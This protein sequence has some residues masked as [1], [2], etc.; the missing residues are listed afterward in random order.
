MTVEDW[1]RLASICMDMGGRYA[2]PDHALANEYYALAKGTSEHEAALAAGKASQLIEQFQLSEAMI[3]LDEPEAE[4]EPIAKDARLEPELQEFGGRGS[5]RK[6]VAWRETIARA[7]ASDLGIH[8]YWGNHIDM[9]GFGRESAIQTWRY[10]FQYLVRAV[11][12]LTDE[13]WVRQ[14]DPE[15]SARSWK[16]AFRS[17]CAQRLAVRVWE[18]R[19][20]RK[21]A[22]AQHAENLTTMS[23]TA[24]DQ[25]SE[26]FDE[27]VD[28]R[29]E[30]QA[31]A[32]IAKDQAQVDDE[33]KAYSKNW[34]GSI[35]GIGSTSSMSGYEHGKAAG[36][37]ISLGGKRA[38]LRSGQGRIGGRS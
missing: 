20:A 12:Q 8:M 1:H 3:R 10:T 21:K 32:I 37:R 28:A 7:L 27:R 26:T 11:D 16:N 33:Y 31:L 19:Q 14:R 6:R 36:D 35:G 22:N 25:E 2:G 34:K 18:E 29:R 38:A 4:P 5:G 24:S 23:E 17:G 30:C 9:R 13:A 15:E